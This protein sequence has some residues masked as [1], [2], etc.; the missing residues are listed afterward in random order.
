M[1]IAVTLV[2]CGGAKVNTTLQNDKYE[3]F[4]DQTRLIMLKSERQIFKHLPDDQARDEFIREF[5]EKRDPSPGT[6]ENENRLEYQYRLE[7]IERWFREK[8]GSH[9]GWDSD[10]GKIYLLLGPPDTRSVRQGNVVDRL[11]KLKR[12]LK[13]IWVYDYYRLYLEFAD[14]EGFGIYRL[15]NWEPEL[16]NAIDRAKFVVVQNESN[17]HPLKF[18]AKY[19]EKGINISIPVKTVSFDEIDAQ[20]KATFNVSVFVYRDYKKIDQLSV[21]RTIEGSKNDFVNRKHLD[22][23]LPY[24]PPEQGKYYFDIIL[25]E[26]A[27]GARYRD[28]IGYKNI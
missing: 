11:G 19:R 27:T 13:E 23:T 20:M 14:S 18:K 15:R 24:S 21:T 3:E 8:I 28:M 4:Y 26:V 10:R 6:P 16:L 12:V 2:A 25:E 17:D 5:W 7:Y 1:I 9:R 22:L